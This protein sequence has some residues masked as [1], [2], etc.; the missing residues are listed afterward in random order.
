MTSKGAGEVE[1][2]SYDVEYGDKYT[3]LVLRR[4][5]T[6]V[7]SGAI[8]LVVITHFTEANTNNTSSL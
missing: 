4:Y 2:R 1:L 8:I 6:D 7:R 3:S 5:L